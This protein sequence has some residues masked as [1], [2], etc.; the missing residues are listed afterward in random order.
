MYTTLDIGARIQDD[1]NEII[2]ID[3]LSFKSVKLKEP[4]TS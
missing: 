2:L 4:I 3:S 1:L